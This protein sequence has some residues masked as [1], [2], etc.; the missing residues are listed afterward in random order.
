MLYLAEVVPGLFTALLSFRRTY[1][2][3]PSIA[4]VLVFPLPVHPSYD[5]ASG[6]DPAGCDLLRLAT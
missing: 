6:E 1:L 2:S 4:S 3:S 5:T